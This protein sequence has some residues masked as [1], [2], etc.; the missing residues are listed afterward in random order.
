MNPLLQV[1]LVIPY[2]T[3]KTLNFSLRYCPTSFITLKNICFTFILSTCFFKHLRWLSQS[4][5]LNLIENL[6]REVKIRVMAKSSSNLRDLELIILEKLSECQWK[7]VKSC[8]A[9]IRT[10]VVVSKLLFFYYYYQ[11]FYYLLTLLFSTC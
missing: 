11:L 4:P 10:A 2:L 3:I 9:P 5:D 6:W 1:Q 8:F 7:C